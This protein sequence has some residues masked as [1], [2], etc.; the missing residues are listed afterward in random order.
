MDDIILP[1]RTRSEVTSEDY[2][3]PAV[4]T[5]REEKCSLTN[6]SP[7]TP[8]DVLKELQSKPS[9]ESLAKILR[10]LSSAATSEI[11][12]DINVP[13]PQAAKIIN[14]LVNSI[15]PDFWN[16]LSSDGTDARSRERQ[17]LVRCLRNTAGIGALI[18]RLRALI[19]DQKTPQTF[20][21]LKTGSQITRDVQPILDVL[22]V[23]KVMLQKNYSI[24]NLR[25][26]VHLS[27]S[28]PA[29]RN[30]IWKE[31]IS[32]LAGGR[33]L[34]VAAEA[35]AAISASSLDIKEGS[36]LGNGQ[37]YATWLSKN[38]H[39]MAISEK[40]ESVEKTKEVSRILSMTLT[41]GYN[42][43]AACFEV[44]PVGH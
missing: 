22:N 11:S 30:L 23:L 37:L 24:A 29:Q 2:L 19:A 16:T 27:I 36:W 42:G 10:W 13:S 18:T 5:L 35:N 40:D 43:A 34:S 32:S 12:F 6:R 14:A 7:Q 9:L 4:A 33:L 31:T 26:S 41:L 39:H 8:E 17:L 44:Q 15:V 3:T 20:N 28:N 25:K 1:S 38:I 21:K